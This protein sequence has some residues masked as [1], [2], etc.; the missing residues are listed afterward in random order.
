M[1]RAAFVGFL[2]EGVDLK[3][4]WTSRPIESWHK[5][6]DMGSLEYYFTPVKTHWF[7]AMHRGNFMKTSAVGAHRMFHATSAVESSLNFQDFSS[8]AVPKRLQPVCARDLGFFNWHIHVDFCRLSAC[9][10]CVDNVPFWCVFSC[11]KLETV[12]R[13]VFRYRRRFRWGAWGSWSGGVG[14]DFWLPPPAMFFDK[15][16]A[17]L[18]IS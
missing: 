17:H 18:R 6:S 7:W 14:V 8:F 2:W 1:E 3:K 4:I 13:W 11:R 5:W 10:C 16:F 15:K 12:N 9:I